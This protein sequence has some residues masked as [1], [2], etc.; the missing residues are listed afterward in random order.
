MTTESSNGPPK[1]A[2]SIEQPSSTT[3]TLAMPQSS[4]RSTNL[5]LTEFALFAKLPIELKDIIWTTACYEPRV[6]EVGL[7]HPHGSDATGSYFTAAL[8]SKTIVPA[9]LHACQGSRKIGLMYYE[10]I[11]L[12]ESPSGSYINW[13]LD[14]LFMYRVARY[15]GPETVQEIKDNPSLCTI[16]QKCRRLLVLPTDHI[17]IDTMLLL[18][19]MPGL[20]E[21]AMTSDSK[22]SLV[23]SN[24]G[25]LKMIDE[26][27]FLLWEGGTWVLDAQFIARR[28]FSESGVIGVLGGPDWARIWRDVGRVHDDMSRSQTPISNKHLKRI[29]WTSAVRVAEKVSACED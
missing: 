13:S 29:T 1:M 10:N 23:R 14:Y 8:E 28:I 19:Q 9:V 24:A 2:Q 11:E 26:D 17:C 15:V 18:S 7:V 6:V 20:E 16:L 27:D 4:P 12:N 22:S 21:V 3:R 5:N 25:T